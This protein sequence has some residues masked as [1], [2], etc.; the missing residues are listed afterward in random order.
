MRLPNGY[1]TVYKLSGNR[2][3][4]F[5]AR[6]T[7]GWDESGKQLMKTVGYYPTRQEALQALAN[8][9][10]NPYDLDVIHVTFSELYE[11]WQ[12]VKFENSSQS[13]IASITAS[14]KW[15]TALY[16]SEFVKLKTPNLQSVI[17]DCP[18]GYS[19]KYKIKSLLN[20]LYAYAMQNDVVTKNYAEYVVLGKRE[21]TT[22]RKPFSQQEINT[23]FELQPFYEW[24]DTVLIMIYSGLRIG[25]LLT[26]KNADINLA[27]RTIRGGIKTDAGRNRLIPINDK[28]FSFFRLRKSSSEYFIHNSKGHCIPYTNYSRDCW[29]PLMKQLHMEHTPHDCRH[30]FAT[31]MSN[32]NANKT[33]IKNIIGHSSYETTERIYTHKDIEEL[34]REI[35]LI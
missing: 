9:N 21:K 29:K 7:I 13:V 20:Q 2:R 22:R 23:L 32:A 33:A 10:T 8:Y 25:E 15:C 4:P 24:A 28:I 14:Y 12:E 1:G 18:K 3:N 30:T 19:T 34:K 31:L 11:R 16:D 35:N 27:N 5:I 26:L 6:K 17:D